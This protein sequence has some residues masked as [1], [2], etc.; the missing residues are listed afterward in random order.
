MNGRYLLDTNVAIQILNQ[1]ID[2]APCK[3]NTTC[4]A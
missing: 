2:L 1:T 3:P 4:C